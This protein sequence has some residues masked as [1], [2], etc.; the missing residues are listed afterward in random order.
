MSLG[1]QG[2]LWVPRQ[3]NE[4]G[5]NLAHGILEKFINSMMLSGI[6]EADNT[7]SQ[8]LAQKRK[9]FIHFDLHYITVHTVM[10]FTIF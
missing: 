8:A 9:T 1:S 5:A 2:L 10:S 6:M 3:H 7:I 4:T